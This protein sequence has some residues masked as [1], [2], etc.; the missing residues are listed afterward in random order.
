[1]AGG[2]YS[3]SWSPAAGLDDATSRT[4]IAKPLVTTTYTVTVTDANGCQV[5]DDIEIVVAPDL[6]ATATTD[7]PL[8]S[9]CP[10][11]RAN[12][13][14][15][16]AGGEELPGGG[17]TYSWAPAAGL[18]NPFSRNPV[19][20]PAATTTYT[21]TVTDANGCTTTSDVLITVADPIA[22]S[23]TAVVY[24][25]G[26]NVSCQGE[27]DGGIDITV[28]GG[29]VPYGFAW[30]GPAGFT[31]TDE[32]ITGLTAG[33]YLLTVTDANGCFATYSVT[34]TSPDELEADAVVSSDYNGRDVSCFG[35]ADGSI[36]LT[37]TGGTAPYSYAWTGPAA[38]TSTDEDPSMLTAGTYNVTVTDDNGCIAAAVITL[39]QPDLLELN[40]TNDQLLDCFGDNDGYGTFY[41]LGGTMPYTFTE[42]TNTAGA[43]LAASGMNSQGIFG[44]SAG[45]ITIRVT[46]VNGCTA[47]ATI[48][49]TQPDP[50][51]PG[52]IGSDQIVCF[53]D[54]PAPIT[55]S[56]PA[57][58]GTGSYTYQWQMT[59]IAGG[60]Y[61][62]IP[63][64][65]SATYDPPAGAS[66]TTWYRNYSSGVDLPVSPA[67]TTTYTLISVEDANNCIVTE[68]TY[69]TF[70]NGSATV[71]VRDNPVITRDPF[72]VTLC[73]Y[74]MT[75][76]GVTATGTDLMYQWEV[77]DGSTWSDITDGGTYFG[78][79]S[80][81]LM[82]FSAT[83]SL[84]GNL[85]R[86]KATTCGVTVTSNEGVLNIET[87]PE[88][89]N[90]PQDTTIC[91]GNDAWMDVDAVGDGLT[92][93]WY[94]NTG[95]G[96]VQVVD[97]GI[98]YSGA[99][100]DSLVIMDAPA[101]FNS[102]LFRVVVS[103]TCGVPVYSGFS[104]LT[105]SN[106]PVAT[107]DPLDDEICEDG[108]VYFVANGYG[109]DSIRWQVDEGSG[110]TELYD[111]VNHLG[112]ASPQL[113]IIDVPVTH[114]S[115]MYRL[116]LYNECDVTYSAAATLTV[117]ENP[118]V[119]FSAIDPLL[120]CGGVPL[121]LNG[122]PAGGSGSYVN[123]RWTGQVGPLNN[124]FI[125]D[126]LFNTSIQGTYALNYAVT[127]SKGCSA[128]G[129]LNVEVERP[130]AS[131][132]PDVTS[133]CPDLTVNFTDNSL[134]AVAYRWDFG[135]GSPVDNTAG[136]V[137]HTY[138][139]D[140]T[141]LLYYNVK[142]EVESINGC[143]DSMVMG[144]TVYPEASA[145]FTLSADTICAGEQVILTSLP[146]AYQYH[147]D[148][149]DGVAEYGSNVINHVYTNATLAP[150]TYTVRLTTTSFYSCAEWI[151][152]DI[153][154]YPTP[155]PL[156]SAD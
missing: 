89:I 44:A 106:P 78:A 49:F 68:A 103:G 13:E 27:A 47:E 64:A 110:W 7:D 134:G 43:T 92:Y 120:A 40:P 28:T 98:N 151:E 94:V 59:T 126:P 91:V 26:W 82:I 33:I 10:T 148:Y 9:T 156:F 138:T 51:L 25:G 35:E 114:N 77:Y 36:D 37:V 60:P 142:L 31:S 150:V 132:A 119:D 39:T 65:T 155:V 108:N 131:F 149:G 100:T 1:L 83:R 55:A 8:I 109:M 81:S 58:G 153:V 32:D 3:W 147:W 107:L 29:E 111:D 104:I 124:Y 86:V 30:S 18:S 95:T 140:S 99:T 21:V 42:G 139:N 88:I 54:D 123:H 61:T 52:V 53:D 24:N 34:L 146:G 79:N 19:A 96:F 46:D 6:T 80:D 69:P 85:Y 117:N 22:I 154:V 125:E 143:I 14:V 11:S 72:D 4:P 152:K 144:V 84:D 63:G 66:V 133:G 20:K 12:L 102:D 48:I 74:N 128:E 118:V 113:T 122:N 105:V 101:E 2:G 73:E 97:D 90:H 141:S 112:S 127:D 76:F 70:L 93:Q 50:L 5:S 67:V 56:T 71:T 57:S 136:D 23:H 15:T 75:G 87:A 45:E 17:Y 38:Y 41:A 115:N 137:S 121:Q 130:T 116:A 135:D 16:V 62:N 129:S 145:D